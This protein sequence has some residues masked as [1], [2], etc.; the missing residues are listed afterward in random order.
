[1]IERAR[2]DEIE[3]AARIIVGRGELTDALKRE[4]AVARRR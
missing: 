2:G 1:M 4:I 3:R